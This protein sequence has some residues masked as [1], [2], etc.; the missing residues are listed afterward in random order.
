VIEEE[1][2]RAGELALPCFVSKCRIAI[3]KRANASR[4]S[5]G[6]HFASC[7]LCHMALRQDWLLRCFVRKIDLYL[8]S[9]NIP[10]DFATPVSEVIHHEEFVLARH[11][12]KGRVMGRRHTTG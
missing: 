8:A 4:A 1:V 9:V 6:Q 5:R 12:F 2:I 3:E 11:R 10:A 7:Q